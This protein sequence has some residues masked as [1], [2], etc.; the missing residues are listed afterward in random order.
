MTGSPMADD[1][2]AP[3][4]WEVTRYRLL[5]FPGKRVLDSLLA[6]AVLRAPNSTDRTNCRER[7]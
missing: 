2:A 3:R 7:G 6:L 5:D 1:E 4:F